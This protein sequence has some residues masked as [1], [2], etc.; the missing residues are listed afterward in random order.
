M[1]MTRGHVYVG[2]PVACTRCGDPWPE[3]FLPHRECPVKS[4]LVV[5]TSDDERVT[6]ESEWSPETAAAVAALAQAIN[7][8]ATWS[9]SPRMFVEPS[10]TAA[11]QGDE[12]A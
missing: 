10:A 11:T 8:K 2:T 5:L 1:D 7:E 6:H 3:G 4:Y 9:A 12:V